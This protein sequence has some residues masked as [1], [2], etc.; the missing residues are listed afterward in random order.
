M[1]NKHRTLATKPL[2]EANTATPTI[3]NG[4]LTFRLPTNTTWLA[5]STPARATQVLPLATG[6]TLAGITEIE[7]INRTV[8]TRTFESHRMRPHCSFAY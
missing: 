8:N 3:T 4:I 7:G 1:I 2:I 6:W 5:M